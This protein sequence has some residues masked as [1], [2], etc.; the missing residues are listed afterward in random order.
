MIRT[1]C[2]EDEKYDDDV[3]K[4]RKPM[5]SALQFFG[6]FRYGHK[7]PCHVYYHETQ[8]EIEEGEKALV[9]ENQVTKA[10]SNSAQMSARK[11]LQVLNEADVNFRHSTR[12]LQHVKKMTITV[13][14]VQEVG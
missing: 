9:W 1:W 3:K 5:G 8:E 12:K 6:A 13:V 11:A 10:Q 14:S 2:K 4:G 7:G